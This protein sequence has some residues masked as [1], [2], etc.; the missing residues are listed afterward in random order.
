[1]KGKINVTKKILYALMILNLSWYPQ[2]SVIASQLQ[3]KKS[4]GLALRSLAICGLGSLTVAAKPCLSKMRDDQSQ[5]SQCLDFLKK[6]GKFLKRASVLPGL[7]GAISCFRLAFRD[8]IPQDKKNGLI[9][10]GL[11]GL[12]FSAAI[13]AAD[14]D[15]QMAIRQEDNKEVK[16]LKCLKN[17]FWNYPYAYLGGG[18][19]VWSLG[20]FD[21]LYSKIAP[22]LQKLAKIKKLF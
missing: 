12:T 20:Y 16:T 15:D 7:V 4:E 10:L 17:V 22:K 8:K 5:D 2:G 1:M 9:G 18:A 6:S 3:I 14:I 21:V 19:L 11:S 13:L